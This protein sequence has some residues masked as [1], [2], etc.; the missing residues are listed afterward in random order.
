MTPLRSFG[1]GL[2]VAFQR[3]AVGADDV[4]VNQECPLG[5]KSQTMPGEHRRRLAAYDM[6]SAFVAADE[7]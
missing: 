5:Q 1:A 6:G 4:R 2:Q 7:P 3:D